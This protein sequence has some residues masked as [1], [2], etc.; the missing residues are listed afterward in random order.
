M[1]LIQAIINESN[2]I[3]STDKN[4]VIV[5]HKLGFI[6]INAVIDL[7]NIP[8]SDNISLL[9]PEDPSKSA[10]NLSEA[11]YTPLNKIL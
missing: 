1:E 2:K 7:S 11:L 3:L 6:N 10:K 4:V 5:E 9:L 8:R